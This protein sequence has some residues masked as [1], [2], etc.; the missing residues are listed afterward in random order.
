VADSITLL[1]RKP[2]YAGM[3]LAGIFGPAI[4]QRQKSEI[5]N[6]QLMTFALTD[7]HFKRRVLRYQNVT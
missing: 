3:A 7:R 5:L 1:Q 4:L 2:L 6:H